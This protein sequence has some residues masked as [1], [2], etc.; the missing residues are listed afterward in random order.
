MKSLSRRELL[1]TGGGVLLLG[2][3]GSK[4]TSSIGGVAVGPTDPAIERRDAL[5]RK[6]DAAT[7]TTMVTAAPATV[8]IG[9]RE[10]STW[11]FGERPSAGGIR[12]KVGDL[13]E[14][15][16]VNQLPVANTMHWHGIAL[17]N[18]MDGVHDLTQAP[19]ETGAQFTYRFTV[20]DA[21]TFWFHPHMGLELDKG[22]YAPL[23]VEDPNDP[24]AFDADVT[25]MLDD[26]LDGYG[27]TQEQVLA[28]LK[29]TGGH[30]GHMGGDPSNS[31][32]VGMGGMGGMGGMTSSSG[33]MGSSSGGMGSMMDGL[34]GDV[35]YPLHLINGR[36]P[37]ERETVKAIP[38][39]RV[40]LRLINAGSDTAYRVAVG[41][42][43]MTV[44]HADGFPVVPVE[45]DNVVL[46][47]GERYDVIVVA[48]SG[49]FPIVAAPEGKTDP[50]AEAVLSTSNSAAVPAI[51]TK[52]SELSGRTLVYADLVAADAVRLAAK[53]PDRSET[54][55]LT[56]NPSGYVHG[57]NAKS[58][59]DSAPI[60]VREGERLRLRIVNNTM[61]FHPIHLHGHTFQ[62]VGDGNAR[63]DTVNVLPMSSV[64]VDIAADNPGQWMLHCHNTY[65]FEMGMATVLSY[66]G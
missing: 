51:G 29:S 45:V 37:T 5:R 31:G 22:L 57:I 56:A 65:H 15:T 16:F 36:A 46:G 4:A 42:H 10:V 58:Y 23:I 13:I 59:P 63:K 24:V 6:A 28:E 18:D 1:A 38:G 21:G 66:R 49:A 8:L 7:V 50:A 2:A 20:P 12:A 55:A 47:M 44:T 11:A 53:R 14:A 34:T 61:M 9:G 52:P 35:T 27:R 17:R 62:M 48:Q 54:I 26:W 32:M 60:V 40:R 3:C 43:R 19:V 39:Q 33:G 64:E 25:L 30:S 41:G